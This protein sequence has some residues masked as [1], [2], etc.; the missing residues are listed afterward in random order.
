MHPALTEALTEN[1]GSKAGTLLQPACQSH[2]LASI[3]PRVSHQLMPG[4]PGEPA[5]REDLLPLCFEKLFQAACWDQAFGH[6]SL[7][8]A[9]MGGTQVPL[10]EGKCLL[11]SSEK[12]Q[13]HT[14]SYCSLPTGD[15]LWC[16]LPGD[17]LV[18]RL[19]LTFEKAS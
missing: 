12:G 14:L 17:A 16:S 2:T 15:A 10:S 8:P 18:Q 4:M 19:I 7:V 1:L 13:L 3:S 6:S 5:R 11:P 9:W